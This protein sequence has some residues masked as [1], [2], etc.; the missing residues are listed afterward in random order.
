MTAI[1]GI[2]YYN[3]VLCVSVLFAGLIVLCL[4]MAG[5]DT[6]CGSLC[7]TTILATRRCNAVPCVSVQFAGLI[8]LCKLPVARDDA[9]GKNL[10]PVQGLITN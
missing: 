4:P 9:K 3:V 8:V 5:D 1:P 10:F 7:G 2:Q 6:K